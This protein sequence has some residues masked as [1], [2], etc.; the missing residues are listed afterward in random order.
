VYEVAGAAHAN[1]RLPR[2][3]KQSEDAF[4]RA[5]CGSKASRFPMHHYFQSTLARL[6]AWAA[7]GVTPPPSQR[8][9]LAADGTPMLDKHGNP[10]GGV[11]S[12]Y[13]DVPTARYLGGGDCS[14][15]G[16]QDSFSGET[17]ASLYRN[18]DDYVSHATRRIN[19]L[20]K[21]GW[22]LPPDALELRE[23]AGKF[24]GLAVR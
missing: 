6:D 2:I 17:L 10:A 12:S 5:T 16:G 1:P 13:L 20:E 7:R 21:D 8:I 24:K 14:M 4:G 22:L 19:E 3:Y 9:A 23:E 18:R 11:R 15:G